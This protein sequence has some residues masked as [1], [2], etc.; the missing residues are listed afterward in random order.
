MIYV[1]EQ[2]SPKRRGPNAH[3]RLRKY[4]LPLSDGHDHG[5]VA[6]SWCVPRAGEKEGNGT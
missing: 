2:D 4:D 1:Q 5:L 6:V 3:H